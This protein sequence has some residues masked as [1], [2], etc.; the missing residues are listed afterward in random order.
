M[1]DFVKA[2][3]IPP[4]EQLDYSSFSLA[5]W[6]KTKQSVSADGE[7]GRTLSDMFIGCATVPGL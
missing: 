4:I 1:T 2:L 5:E 3:I 7:F 6:F